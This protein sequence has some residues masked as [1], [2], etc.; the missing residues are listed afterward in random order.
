[1][2]EIVAEILSW[3]Q[4]LIFWRKKKKRRKFE[5]RHN[6]PK[7]RMINPLDKLVGILLFLVVV[8]YIIYYVFFSSIIGNKKTLNK[9]VEIELKLEAE[10]D[11]FGKYPKELKG[12]IRNNPLL[13]DII[14]DY[15]NNEF[16]YKQLDNGKKYSLISKG[17]DGKL[18]TKDDVKPKII[19][20][21]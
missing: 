3:I 2:L 20:T 4:D 1:M 6:L 13:K 9:I 7:K 21:K 10:V 12:I 14:H 19:I 8:L 15:W 16:Y 18:F 5:K 11:K 17:K